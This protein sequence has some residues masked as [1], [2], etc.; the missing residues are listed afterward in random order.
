MDVQEEKIRQVVSPKNGLQR[1]HDEPRVKFIL[2]LAK[3]S[4]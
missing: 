1:L 2:L 4:Q 3:Q